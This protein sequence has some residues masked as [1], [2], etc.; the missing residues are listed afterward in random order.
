MPCEVF[1]NAIVCGPRQVVIEHKGRKWR[2]D[3]LP[4]CGA[5][6]MRARDGT[7]GDLLRVP[8]AVWDKLTEHER[9]RNGH[10]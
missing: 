5:A 6:L 8:N 9:R 2:F 1:S 4:G 10:K 7:E 3:I